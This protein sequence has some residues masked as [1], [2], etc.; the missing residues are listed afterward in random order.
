MFKTEEGFASYSTNRGHDIGIVFTAQTEELFKAWSDL[1]KEKAISL[2]LDGF[3]SS[4]EISYGNYIKRNESK[5]KIFEFVNKE[6]AKH[7]IVRR[8][9]DSNNDNSLRLKSL[10]YHSINWISNSGCKKGIDHA[11]YPSSYQKVISINDL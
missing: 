6:N 9:W 4:Y 2:R 3:Y 11:I 1:N 10:F 5:K 7:I 8:F